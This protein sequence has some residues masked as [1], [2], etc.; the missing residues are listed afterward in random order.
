MSEK[1]YVAFTEEMKDSYTILAP[2][3]LPI[4][5]N[6]ILQVMRD[7]G[8]TIDLLTE[9]GPEVAETGLKYVHNDTCYP[10]ILVIGQFIR[11]IESGKYDPRKVALVYF[12]TGGGCRASNYIF[13][14]RKALAKA[15]HPYVPVISISFDGL[16]EHPGFKLTLPIWYRMFYGILY[17]DLIM[18]LSEQVKPY[19]K[20][21]GDA[22]AL[23]DRLSFAL[24]DEMKDGINWKKAEK[25]MAQIIAEFAAIPADRSAKK[26]RVG[27]VGEI[28]VKFSPLG[29]NHLAD[30][31]VD[32]GAEVVLPGLLNFILY[33]VYNK[34][35]DYRL[36]HRGSYLAYKGVEVVYNFLLG[37]QAKM[38]QLMEKSGVFRASEP[39]DEV[40]RIADKCIGHGCKMGEGWLLPA[41]MLSLA[42]HGTNNI[43]CAQPFGCL[44]NHICGKGMMKPIKQHYPNANIVAIDYD[45]SAT[46]VNQENRIKLMLANANADLTAK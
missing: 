21:K 20:H 40:V 41:E 6:L 1:E 36:Y 14:L 22:Q 34:I 46:R 24:A 42:E 11:A 38:A 25:R 8:Y 10:A 4:H 23:A 18:A 31:L 43:V 15:G 3:M 16:E 27:I 7:N 5:F 37:K 28:Y 17:A 9:S 29:N 32:N 2:N 12:Q 30:F 35:E 26:P 33:C 19:E 44:P 13:L 45:A 39:F